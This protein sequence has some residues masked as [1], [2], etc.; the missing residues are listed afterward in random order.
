MPDPLL[1]ILQ[2]TAVLHILRTLPNSTNSRCL[3]TFQQKRRPSGNREAPLNK[4]TFLFLR[5]KQLNITNKRNDFVSHSQLDRFSSKFEFNEAFCVRFDYAV[6]QTFTNT[7]QS[8]ITGHQ[9]RRHMKTRRRDCKINSTI[10]SIN[11]ET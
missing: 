8:N 3:G 4:S 6:R 11:T 7:K 10:F 5:F 2:A 1:S 9:L